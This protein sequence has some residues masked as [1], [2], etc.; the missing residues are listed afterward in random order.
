MVS[1]ANS[2]LEDLAQMEGFDSDYEMLEAAVVDSVVPGICRNEGCDYT[3]GV[4]PDSDSG[5]C[6]EC[7]TNTVESCLML[8]GVI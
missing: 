8:A 6:E 4:E 3:V 5:W 7:E 1:M 2:K